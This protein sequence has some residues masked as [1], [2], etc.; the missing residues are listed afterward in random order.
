VVDVAHACQLHSG[1]NT[2]TS[3]ELDAAGRDVDQHSPDLMIS[4][5]TAS[6]C[7]AMTSSGLSSTI[8]LE[9]MARMDVNGSVL[10]CSIAGADDE[11]HL[12]NPE[13]SA[14]CNAWAGPEI[15]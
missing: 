5:V 10:G 13:I 7:M 4:R 11:S 8:G 2:L 1:Q 3:S 9:A 12:L 14:R 6:R 15:H